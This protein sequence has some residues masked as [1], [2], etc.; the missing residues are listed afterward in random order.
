MCFNNFIIFAIFIGNVLFCLLATYCFVYWQRIVLFIGNVLFCLL[1]TYCFVRYGSTLVEKNELSVSALSWIIILKPCICLYCFLKVGGLYKALFALLFA[2]W[3]IGQV[4]TFI[5]L[6]SFQVF[7]FFNIVASYMHIFQLFQ[8]LALSLATWQYTLITLDCHNTARP[9]EGLNHHTLR[10]SQHCP[11]WRRP[12]LPKT[13]STLS[14]IVLV[15]H[16]YI[17]LLELLLWV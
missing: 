2:G 12:R 6:A 5:L 10:F 11:T 8:H 9:G 16:L 13:R 17:V 7:H 4:R 15:R 3:G 14:S 1:A